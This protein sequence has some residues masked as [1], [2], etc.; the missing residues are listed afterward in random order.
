MAGPVG[1]LALALRGSLLALLGPCRPLG[2]FALAFELA[3]LTLDLLPLLGRGQDDGRRGGVRIGAG[4][5]GRALLGPRL[6]PGG[7][8]LVGALAVDRRGRTWP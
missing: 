2:R 1:R 7:D 6:D 8:D 3:G 5:V 4:L